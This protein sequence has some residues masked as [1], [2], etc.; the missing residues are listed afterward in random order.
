M[1]W[2][3]HYI[4][5]QPAPYPYLCNAHTHGMEHYHHMDFQIVLNLPNDHIC[6]ILNTLGHRVQNGEIFNDGDFVSGIYSDCNIRLKK[7]RETG[8][9]V[10]RVIIPDTH[11][12]FPDNPKCEEKYMHQ[13]L[14]MFENQ[15][16]SCPLIG[17]ASF[18]ANSSH[19]NT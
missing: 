10:L 7:V 16:R 15:H 11:N 18:Y 3:I 13:D 6:Y 5:D 9:D 2:I 14:K 19:F 17:T 4:I 1:D 12:R 8:R